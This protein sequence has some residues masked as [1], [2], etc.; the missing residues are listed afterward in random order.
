MNPWDVYL[1]DLKLRPISFVIDPKAKTMYLKND[2]IYIPKLSPIPYT[3]LY[4][5]ASLL[6]YYK[7]FSKHKKKIKKIGDFYFVYP[8][9]FKSKRSDIFS[10]QNAQ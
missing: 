6:I 10:F 1:S 8:V 4:F 7:F 2:V 5:W 3:Y 9:R